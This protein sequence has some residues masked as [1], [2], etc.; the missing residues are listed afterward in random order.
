M[1][2]QVYHRTE[3]AYAED[4]TN[5]SNELRLTPKITRTQELIST[6]IHVLPATRLAP[7]FR[8]EFDIGT[9]LQEGVA[10]VAVLTALEIAVAVAKGHGIRP[11]EF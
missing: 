9:V 11:I 8:A 10:V 3:Y 5:N 1:R 7:D 2:L 4:V 6:L